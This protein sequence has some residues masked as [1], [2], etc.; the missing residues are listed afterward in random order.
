MVQYGLSLVVR[1]VAGKHN[2]SSLRDGNVRQP[3]VTKPSSRR[4]SVCLASSRRAQY[5]RPATTQV[6]LRSR[7]SGEL[8]V[9]LP[10]KKLIRIAGGTAKLMVEMRQNDP[11]D[12][13][14]ALKLRRSPGQSNAVWT[15]R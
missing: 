7:A 2:V 14:F 12:E 3:L 6:K 13:A 15:S 9:Q 8:L 10:H 11:A 5:I 4:L 1:G